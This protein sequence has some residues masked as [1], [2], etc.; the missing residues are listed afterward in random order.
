MTE[1]TTKHYISHFERGTC[2]GYG[3]NEADALIQCLKHMAEVYGRSEP[4]QVVTANRL[5]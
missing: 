3:E 2:D 5:P 1:A 4:P